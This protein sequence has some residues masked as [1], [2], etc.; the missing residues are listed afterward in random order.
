MLNLL[1]GE[2]R[3]K[4]QRDEFSGG[5]LGGGE[6]LPG[7]DE[8]QEGGLH[9]QRGGIVDERFNAMIREK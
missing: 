1:L 7:P 5:G 6:T 9:G 2:F 8:L 4:G 3:M